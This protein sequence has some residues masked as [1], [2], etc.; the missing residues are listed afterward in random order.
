MRYEKPEKDSS[1]RAFIHQISNFQDTYENQQVK[2][3][4][5]FIEKLIMY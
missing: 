4:R 2:D 1:P 3:K 5:L